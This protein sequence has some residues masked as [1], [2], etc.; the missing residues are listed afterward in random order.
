M[1]EKRDN[2]E[3]QDKEEKTPNENDVSETAQDLQAVSNPGHLEI[4]S[5]EVNV[6]VVFLEICMT[7][8][9]AFC[10][11]ACLQVPTGPGENQHTDV[12]VFIILIILLFYVS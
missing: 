6:I 4:S 7:P 11:K 5:P 10:G 3:G 12:A 1:A 2:E 8:D 9:M